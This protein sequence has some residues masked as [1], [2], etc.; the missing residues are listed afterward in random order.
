M[1]G[2]NVI[3]NKMQVD[4]VRSEMENRQYV[5]DKHLSHELAFLDYPSIAGIV[6]Y[7]QLV[8]NMSFLA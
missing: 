3:K 6:F 8:I 1:S 2:K 4:D 5:S 7:V